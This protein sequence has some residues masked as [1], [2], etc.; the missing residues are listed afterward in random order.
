[1]SNDLTI[2]LKLV[3]SAE[4]ATKPWNSIYAEPEPKQRGGVGGAVGKTESFRDSQES[5]DFCLFSCPYADTECNCH[6][7]NRKGL[8]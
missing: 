8:P 5:I 7:I 2:V 3:E 1:M 6:C 4:T